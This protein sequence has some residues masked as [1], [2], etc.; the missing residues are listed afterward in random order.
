[1]RAS[2]QTKRRFASLLALALCACAATGPAA[3]D[4]FHVAPVRPVAQLLPIAL[5][6]KPPA[7]TGNFRPSDLVE[8]TTLDRT[9]KLDIRYATARNFLGTPLYSQ[10]RAFL[11]R[12]AAEALMRVQRS[13]ASE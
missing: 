4:V 11:Q 1:M 13:L 6:S 9:I 10:A 12:P 2:L 8:L 7:E 5:A 3:T